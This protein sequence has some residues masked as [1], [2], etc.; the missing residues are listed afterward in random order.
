MERLA[1]LPKDMVF[2]TQITMEVA[3]DAEYLEAMRKAR[4]KGALVGVEAVT[5]EGLQ[6]IFKDFNRSGEDLV[7]QLQTFSEHG[8][9]VGLFIFGLPTDNV[10]TFSATAALAQRSGIAFAQFVM[11]TPFPGTIDFERWEKNQNGDGAAVEGIPVTRYGLIPPRLRPK[12][13]MHHPSMTSDEIRE[14]TQEVWD[15]F[16]SLQFIWKRSQCVSTLRSRLGFLF[17][18]KLYRQMSQYRRIAHAKTGQ[19]S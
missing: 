16:Y 10:D 6:A 3:E 11:L 19:P 8:V 18:S 5:P 9:H 1:E 13:F 14:R 17:I 12:M 7:R 4:I 2:F 15:R